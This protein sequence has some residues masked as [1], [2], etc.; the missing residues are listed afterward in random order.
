LTWWD[1]EEEL[2]QKV[3]CVYKIKHTV[4][5]GKAIMGNTAEITQ[6]KNMTESHFELLWMPHG[7]CW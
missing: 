3:T 5:M 6:L 2:I 4:V 1:V 7:K